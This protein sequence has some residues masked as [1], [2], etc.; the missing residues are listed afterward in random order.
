VIS[1]DGREEPAKEVN[2][3]HLVKEKNHF[4]GEGTEHAKKRLLA[5][6]PGLI[7]SYLE[8]QFVNQ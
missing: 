6:V 2:K 7:R 5:H 1:R 3:T 8:V 4:R